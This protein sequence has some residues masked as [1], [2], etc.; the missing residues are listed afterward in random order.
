VALVGR[1][2]LFLYEGKKPKF[3]DIAQEEGTLS[4][5]LEPVEWGKQMAVA[6]KAKDVKDPI[7]F[8]I[9][10]NNKRDRLDPHKYF[11]PKKK[12]GNLGLTVEKEGFYIIRSFERFTLPENIA[13]TGFA[14][15]EHLGEVRIHYAGFAHP[16]FGME[17]KDNKIGTP[18]IFEVR[19]HNFDVILRH[20]ENFAK[21]RF[22]RMSENA[23][24]PKKASYTDQ[25]FMIN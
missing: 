13:V 14:Y 15:T 25:E 4:I 21:I 24:K 23:P 1:R 8:A 18:L 22:F 2:L 19:A 12:W 16:W 9:A 11:E 6:L 5:N 7:D 20:K 17:R 10:K 3:A